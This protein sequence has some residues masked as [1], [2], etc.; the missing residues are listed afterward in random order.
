VFQAAD[1]QVRDAL[2]ISWH[3]RERTGGSPPHQV[4]TAA[5]ASA[6]ASADGTPEQIHLTWGTDP[7]TSVTVS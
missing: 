4:F 6:A 3:T 2:L 5:S 1:E 7:A